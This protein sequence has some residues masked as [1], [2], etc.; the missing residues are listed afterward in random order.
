VSDRWKAESE[1]SATEREQRNRAVPQ[2]RAIEDRP[3]MEPHRDQFGQI[4][5]GRA[6]PGLNSKPIDPVERWNSILSP[7][8]NFNSF[9]GRQAGGDYRPASWLFIEAS[10]S[11]AQC[12]TIRPSRFPPGSLGA[13]TFDG[14]KIEAGAPRSRFSWTSLNRHAGSE[15]RSDLGATSPVAL[16]RAGPW[17]AP[18][19]VLP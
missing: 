1:R 18:R 17:S 4:V 10:S 16:H 11:N 7:R 6:R 19:S 15:N 12:S 2:K 9:F 14:L 13:F 5:R 8:R 3:F